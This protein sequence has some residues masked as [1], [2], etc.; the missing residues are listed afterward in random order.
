MTFHSSKYIYVCRQEKILKGNQ[1]G[2][3]SET[4]LFPVQICGFAIYGL[5][6]TNLRICNL[7][8][9]TPQKFADLRLLNDPK[10]F[11]SGDLRS[12]AICG[13]TKKK[14]RAHL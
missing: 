5:I 6:I 10:N 4:L 1:C 3:G 8:T 12:W 14:W 2:S 11:R 9:D 7:Q 13:L